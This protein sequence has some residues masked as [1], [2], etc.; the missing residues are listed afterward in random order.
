MGA[1]YPEAHQGSGSAWAWGIL[2]HAIPAVP[3]FFSFAPNVQRARAC[4]HVL[5]ESIV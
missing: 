1:M 2:E 5:V 3:I 4:L